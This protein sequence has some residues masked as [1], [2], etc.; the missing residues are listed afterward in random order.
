[1]QN[2]EPNC[3]ADIYSFAIIMWQLKENEIP[4]SL[5]KANE[6]IIWNV[7]RRNLR[8][9]SLQLEFLSD[10]PNVFKRTRK[11]FEDVEPCSKSES[12]FLKVRKFNNFPITPKSVNRNIEQRKKTAIDDQSI[13][14]KLVKFASPQKDRAAI[15]R[16]RLFTNKKLFD[17]KLSPRTDV[18]DNGNCLEDLF[19]DHQ[20]Q[21]E[22]LTSMI[23]LEYVKLYRQCWSRDK[24]LRYDAIK[25]KNLIQD[26]IDSY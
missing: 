13:C 4:Y 10:V 23:E 6:T 12:S 9:D 15:S 21:S 5:I 17:S 11:S 26:L 7:V 24:R 3:S 18:S 22:E 20:P 2:Q 8:P 16:K 25:V 19:I 14:E 1:M